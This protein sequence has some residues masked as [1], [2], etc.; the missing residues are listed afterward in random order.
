[1]TY[2][3]LVS[4]IIKYS[5]RDDAS[6]VNQ[7]PML[8]GL[9]EQA[10]AAEIKTLWE[11]NVVQTN[12]I[13][14]NQGATITKPARWRKTISM[15]I[16]GQPLTHRSQDYVAMYQAESNAGKPIFY[17]DYDYDHW[18]I[19]PIPDSTYPVEIIYYSRV[20]PLDVTNQENLITREVPQALLYGTL[21]QAQGYLKSLD[22]LEVWQKMYDKA[23]A[24][25]KAEDRARNIDRNTAVQE[26]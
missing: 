1:M 6:F 13:P 9:A 17:S 11:L 4:D 23:M 18:A 25:F 24:A 21:L 19:A 8:I 15:K 12:L 2:D 3:N 22:K 16:N 14:G 20:Q 10:I 5:E 7:I 26:P